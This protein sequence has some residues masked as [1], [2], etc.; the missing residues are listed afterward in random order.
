MLS[1]LPSETPLE[2]ALPLSLFVHLLLAFFSRQIYHRGFA[3]ASANM[4]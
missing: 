1:Q 3:S 2:F 4:P